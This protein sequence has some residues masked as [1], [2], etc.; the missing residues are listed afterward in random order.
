M[1]VNVKKNGDE[2]ADLEIPD[3]CALC[4]GPLALRVNRRG[5]ISVCVT[6]R[7]VARPSVELGEGGLQVMF[8]PFAAA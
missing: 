2:S 5:A 4:S 7:W 1:E 6:C 8:S 3:G